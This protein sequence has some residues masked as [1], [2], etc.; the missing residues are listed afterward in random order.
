MLAQPAPLPK[1]GT[2][3]GKAVQSGAMATS[4]CQAAQQTESEK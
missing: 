2:F 3:W 4:V 1:S